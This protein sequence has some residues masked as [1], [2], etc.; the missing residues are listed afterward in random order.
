MSGFG[1]NEQSEGLSDNEDILVGI[2]RV[3]EVLLETG[4]G[5]G[6]PVR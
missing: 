6:S 1:L 4:P 2:Y 3:R 5:I